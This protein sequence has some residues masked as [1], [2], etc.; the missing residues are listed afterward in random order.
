VKVP[1]RV[2]Q[3]VLTKVQPGSGSCVETTYSVGSHGYGQVGWREVDGTVRMALTH[4]VAYAAYR[5]DIPDGLTVDHICRNRRCINPMHLRL[6]TNVANASD[7]G[8]ARKTHC[9]EGHPYEGDNVYRNPNT[10]HRYCRECARIRRQA[11]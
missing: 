6:L 3:R 2:V 5:G 7:N 1:D 8:N 9:P 10:G 4:R 11:S